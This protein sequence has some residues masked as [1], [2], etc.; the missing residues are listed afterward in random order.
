MSTMYIVE[1]G[2]NPAC[3]PADTDSECGCCGA[4]FSDEFKAKVEEQLKLLDIEVE[5]VG[6]LGRMSLPSF[7]VNGTCQLGS[8][9]RFVNDICELG[10]QCDACAYNA[11]RIQHTK[12]IQ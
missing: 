3:S 2:C 1:A 4:W 6:L 12:E 9:S 7:I 5:W 8:D 11:D 10:F